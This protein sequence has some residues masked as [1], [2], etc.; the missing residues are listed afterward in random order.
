VAKVAAAAAASSPYSP[1]FPSVAVTPMAH[2]S[3]VKKV[4]SLEA[5]PLRDSSESNHSSGLQSHHPNGS[6]FS[7]LGN[8]KILSKSKDPLELNGS[9][10]K[11]GHPG[12]VPAENGVHSDRSNV[13]NLQKGPIP[14]RTN[15]GFVGR[16]QGR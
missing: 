6:G 13:G 16:Q 5:K 2:T 9:E 3:R 4:P 14:A 12:S 15:P 10:F 8:V 1:F 11:P 7:V